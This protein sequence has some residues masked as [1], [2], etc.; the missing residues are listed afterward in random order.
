MPVPKPRR[1]SSLRF[2]FG[3]LP[4]GSLRRRRILGGTAEATLQVVEDE[5]HGRKGPCRRRNPARVPSD[6]EDAALGGRRLQLGDAVAV[7]AKLAC[8][9]EQLGAGPSQ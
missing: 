1:P 5:P 3:L 7:G 8:A 6:D 4:P 9:R 2:I